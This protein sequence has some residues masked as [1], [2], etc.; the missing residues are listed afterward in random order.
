M[1]PQKLKDLIAEKNDRRE[2]E[3]LRTA[4]Q[5]IDDIAREQE[6]IRRCNANIAK[7]REELKTLSVNT[8][9]ASEVLGE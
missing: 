3:T 4:E 8:L 7:L 6:S 2:R 9:D 5:L 1:D